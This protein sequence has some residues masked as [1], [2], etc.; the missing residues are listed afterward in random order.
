MLD[1]FSGSGILHWYGFSPLWKRIYATLDLIAWKMITRDSN[2]VSLQYV[3]KN[4][5]IEEF[6]LEKGCHTLYND[7]A[8]ISHIYAMLSA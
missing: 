8:Y 3:W 6:A 4:D 2:M 7:M 5:C 1:Y